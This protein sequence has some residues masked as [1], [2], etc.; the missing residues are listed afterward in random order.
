MIFAANFKTNH[1]RAQT[2]KYLQHLDSFMQFQ[3]ESVEC[4][5]FPPLTALDH[6]GIKQV[7]VGVQNAYP[8][9]NGAVTGEVGMQQLNEFAINSI[10]IGHSERRAIIGET[11]ETI[12]D[13]FNF[14]KE[15]GFEIIYCIGEDLQT[16]QSG[17]LKEFLNAQLEGIDLGYDKLIVAYE[18]VWAIGTGES[19][20]NQTIKK[21]H[22]MI[23]NMIGKTP[24]LYG[25]SVKPDSVGQITAI[26][27]VDGVLVG[28]A[29]LEVAS[30]Q[31]IITNAK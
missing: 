17:N 30:F 16:R 10:L 15:R 22:D 9:D 21:T 13:K 23:K 14:Y 18:P 5:V 26:D 19:A 28:S 12:V 25:G 7:K 29:S 20:D 2:Q 11:Q 1:T 3:D 24:L 31:Q 27:S 6:Y 4:F 8:I